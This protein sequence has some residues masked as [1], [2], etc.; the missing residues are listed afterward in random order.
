MPERDRASSAGV[1]PACGKVSLRGGG[2]T[3]GMRDIAR[4]RPVAV[5]VTKYEL[6]KMFKRA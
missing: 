3:L 5:K 4:G 2:E 1:N 6:E